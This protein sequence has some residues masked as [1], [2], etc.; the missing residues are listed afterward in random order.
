MRPL[1]TKRVKRSASGEA[2]S[3]LFDGHHILEEA[4]AEAR[5]RFAGIP[6]VCGIGVGRK[7]SESRGEYAKGDAALSELC[8]QIM[9]DVKRDSESLPRAH[10]LPKF[11]LVPDPAN[12]Q[13]KRVNLDVLSVSRP[14]LQLS[15]HVHTW[16]TAGVIEMG[17]IFVFGQQSA[18]TA[19]GRFDGGD[20]EIGTVG[21]LLKRGGG[22]VLA[23]T[24]GHVFIDTCADDLSAPV[25][26][27]RLGV[28]GK[29]W[30]RIPARSFKPSQLIND[31]SLVEDAI[32]LA[33]PSDMV[34]SDPQWP[35][36]FDGMV[37]GVDDILA[38]IRSDGG[39]G[40]T[41]VERPGV[42]NA[43]LD[44]DLMTSI[45]DFSPIMCGSERISYTRVWKYRY[46]GETTVAGDSGAGVFIRTSDNASIRLLGFHFMLDRDNEHGYAVDARSF[47]VAAFGGLPG[48][49]Y[50]FLRGT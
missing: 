7:F 25:D 46:S 10:R 42:A 27:R 23:V 37:A 41:W 3:P 49:G 32:C 12:G 30:R 2:S 4:V 44:I 39:R 48:A 14:V 31:D 34:S 33:I 1:R 21:A 16:P 38:A 29:D 18:D 5:R 36:G 13:R 9:V 17:R 11:I 40:F 8:V 6:G 28:Q 50:D 15:S 43:R 22:V 47:L 35:A 20:A 45:D 24:A 26:A 19:S